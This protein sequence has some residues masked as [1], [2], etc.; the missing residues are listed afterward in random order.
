MKTIKLSVISIL[1]LL[2]CMNFTTNNYDTKC[3]SEIIKV[4][5][6]HKQTFTEL[7]ELQSKLLKEEISLNFH[8]L[9]FDNNGYLTAIE[10]KVFSEGKYCGTG[11]SKSLSD[12]RKFGFSIDKT[13]NAKPYFSVGNI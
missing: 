7:V 2:V 13:L 9:E 3:S 1:I 4:Y 6:S 5:F 12:E 10:F 11:L 8:L